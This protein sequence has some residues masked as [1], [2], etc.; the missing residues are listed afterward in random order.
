MMK[1]DKLEEQEAYEI[2]SKMY[3]EV[4]KWMEKK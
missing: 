3:M 1:E 2:T 4:K